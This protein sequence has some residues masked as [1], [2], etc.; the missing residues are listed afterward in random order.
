MPV[1]A[2]NLHLDSRLCRRLFRSAIVLTVLTTL[3]MLLVAGGV[4]I[5]GRDGDPANAMYLGI[6]ALLLSGGV[7]SRLNPTGMAVT[8][9][10]TLPLFLIIVMAAF[11]MGMQY[12]PHNSVFEI[13]MVNV[14]FAGLYLL[15]GTLFFLSSLNRAHPGR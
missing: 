13:L 12:A 8:L 6:V 5:L 14:F 1:F 7:I 15:S 3:F 4:G 10:A 2:M 11:A 9:A